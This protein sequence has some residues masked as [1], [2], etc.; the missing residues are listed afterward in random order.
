MLYLIPDPR[1]LISDTRIC[2]AILITWYLTPVFVM[3]YLSLDIQHRYLPCYTCHLISYTCT[4]HAI[5]ITWYLT[6]VLAM[7][8]LTLDILPPGTNTL[9]L[10]LWHLTG[11]Y[12][13]GHLYFLAYSWL[14]L[15][16]GLDYYIVT[17]HLVLLNSW[18][19]VFLNPW[20]RVTPD[21]VLLLIPVIV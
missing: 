19:P 9:D 11:Y 15:L 17:R 8:H 5:L 13:T 1:H 16:R 4:Y 21:T 3:L 14:S 7:L 10:I 18:T 6:P 20:K 2:H 12:Y